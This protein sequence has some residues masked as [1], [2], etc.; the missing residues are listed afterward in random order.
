MHYPGSSFAVTLNTFTSA[1][2][3]VD[4]DALPTGKLLLAGADSGAVVTVT[5][6]RGTGT[7]STRTS[8]T[9]GVLTVAE[10]HG[11]VAGDVIDV[12]WDGGHATSGTVT[13]ADDTTITFESATGDVLPIEDA[14]C[15]CTRTGQAVASVTI[16][17][18]ATPGA[19]YELELTAAVDG[20]MNRWIEDRCEVAAQSAVF[21]SRVVSL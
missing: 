15:T 6:T 20:T 2:E 4:T 12:Y 3:L 14:D 16:P 10:G 8:D 17:A 5:R 9:A 19:V 1:G 21:G 11:I 7:L 13:D 18:S